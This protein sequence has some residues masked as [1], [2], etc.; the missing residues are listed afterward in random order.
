[1]TNILYKKTITIHILYKACD[2]SPLSVYFE[3]SLLRLPPKIAASGLYNLFAN[4]L[5]KVLP[6][7][8]PPRFLCKGFYCGY[9]VFPSCKREAKEFIILLGAFGEGIIGLAKLVFQLALLVCKN[10]FCDKIWPVLHDR[11]T[12]LELFF[13]DFGEH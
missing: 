11:R 7:H 3:S 4:F 8:H 1:M 10:Y 6:S 2:I 9:L 12:Y 13:Q 5:Q